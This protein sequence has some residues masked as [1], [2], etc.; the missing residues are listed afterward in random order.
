M[1]LHYLRN[2]PEKVEALFRDIIDGS[3]DTII[4]ETI[5]IE[6]FKHL[7]VSGGKEYASD[8]I[9]SIYLDGKVQIVPLNRLLVISAGKLKCQ[10]RNVLSYNDCILIAV[11]L[12]ERATVHTT[13]KEW[14]KIT[15]LDVVK[16]TF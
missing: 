12:K 16:Y 9:N 15:H 13:E 11:A 7:C 3:V 4:P 5:L 14:P 6:A 8:V 2:P 10:H 1:Q